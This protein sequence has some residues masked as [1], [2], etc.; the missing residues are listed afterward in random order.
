MEDSDN[1]PDKSCP[2]EMND[3]SVQHKECVDMVAA[4]HGKV[5]RSKVFRQPFV[6]SF[7]RPFGSGL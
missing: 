3:P 7:Y 4:R 6:T 1:G 2:A 5:L